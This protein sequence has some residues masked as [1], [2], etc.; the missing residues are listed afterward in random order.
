[1]HWN[2]KYGAWAVV[3]GASDGIGQQLAIELAKRGPQSPSGSAPVGD[4]R[5]SR[6]EEAL[7]VGLLA[8]VAGYG[9]SGDFIT[10]DAPRELNMVDVNCRAVVALSHAFTKRFVAQQRG[11]LPR[12]RGRTQ[13][14]A[15]RA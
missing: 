7:E 12:C 8:A 13:L 6:R 2:N 9:T 4:S 14:R 10:I 1:M 11:G 5:A 3:T 15:A